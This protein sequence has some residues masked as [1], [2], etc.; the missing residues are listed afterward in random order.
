M[1]DSLITMH[2]AEILEWEAEDQVFGVLAEEPEPVSDEEVL[3]MLEQ[4]RISLPR[5]ILQTELVSHATK[6]KS[7]LGEGLAAGDY[8]YFLVEVPLNILV[9]EK[10]VMVRLRLRLDLGSEDSGAIAYDLFPVDQWEVGEKSL[11]EVNIDVSKLL[12][13]A[14]P[15][16]IADCLGF[17]L[18][19]PIKW[20]THTVNVRS[21]DRMSNPA[22]WYIKDESIQHGFIGHLIVRAP[23]SETVEISATLACELRMAGLYGKIK[24]KQ[25]RSHRQ[26]YLLKGN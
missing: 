11:G 3:A 15:A 10:Y 23:K 21:S 19:F 14:C 4:M 12:T 18:N 13:F 26:S 6:I 16:P 8:S 1:E 25:F 24:K 17:K 7:P 2:P 20:K 5:Q 22:E 9:P